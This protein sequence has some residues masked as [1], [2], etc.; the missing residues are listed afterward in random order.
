MSEMGCG[1]RDCY[2]LVMA[3]LLWAADTAMNC[4]KA[5]GYAEPAV[6]KRSFNSDNLNPSKAGQVW[7][8]CR[9]KSDLLRLHR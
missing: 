8:E 4:S 5:A 9:P 7:N 6:P 3:L 2:W 1:A